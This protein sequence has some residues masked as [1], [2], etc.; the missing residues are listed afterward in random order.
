MVAQL[1]MYFVSIIYILGIVVVGSLVVSVCM[2]TIS[3][4]LTNIVD[5]LHKDDDER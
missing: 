2:A 3:R 1:A 4:V 5:A